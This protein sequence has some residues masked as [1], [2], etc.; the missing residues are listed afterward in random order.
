MIYNLNGRK[1][2]SKQRKVQ[3]KLASIAPTKALVQRTPSMQGVHS[4]TYPQ[5]IFSESSCQ[6]LQ[7]EFFQPK[8]ELGGLYAR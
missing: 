2:K 7:K 1:W 3:G 4:S 8:C 5:P 6:D